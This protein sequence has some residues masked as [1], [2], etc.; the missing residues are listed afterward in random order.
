MAGLGIALPAQA[1]LV[2]TVSISWNPTLA[3][4]VWP[5]DFNRDGRT[6]LVAGV[7]AP[8]GPFQSVDLVVAIGRGDG[9]FMPPTSLGLAAY[10]LTV[11]DLNADGLLD[12]LI[13]R[14]NWIEVLPG[15]GD[16]TFDAPVAAVESV[17]YGDIRAWAHVND[18]DGDGHRD[19]IAPMD[20][21][22]EIRDPLRQRRPHVRPADRG[23]GLAAARRH[24]QRR[25]QQRRPP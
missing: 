22:D 25:L 17:Q 24:H 10:P 23:P 3:F 14:N 16:A 1:P 19:I 21:F 6:D 20:T 8:G 5:A 13:L 9:T 15:N 11:S 18:F 12:V 2:P 7:D 4:N